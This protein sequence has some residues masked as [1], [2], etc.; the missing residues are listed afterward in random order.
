MLSSV[1]AQYHC[2]GQAHN[3]QLLSILTTE[4]SQWTI[5]MRRCDHVRQLGRRILDRRGSLTKSYTT[6][7]TRHRL[8]NT[9]TIWFVR[10]VATFDRPLS[11]TPGRLTKKHRIGSMWKTLAALTNSSRPHEQSLCSQLTW[12]EYLLPS[13]LSGQLMTCRQARLIRV[14]AYVTIKWLLSLPDE[15]GKG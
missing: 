12:D 7:S 9:T 1:K 4:P 5:T 2:E 14:Q 10:R 8:L 15:L 6:A 3:L 13:H 11:A